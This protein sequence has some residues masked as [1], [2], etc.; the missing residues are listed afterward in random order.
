MAEVALA[1]R[2]ASVVK[3]V[4]ERVDRVA[5]R[6]HGQ[7]LPLVALRAQALVAGRVLT[8]RLTERSGDLLRTLV[9]D[10][11]AHLLRV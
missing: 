8:A 4:R 7:L 1:G 3:I 5:R 10:R 11:R 6:A 9:L 2:N